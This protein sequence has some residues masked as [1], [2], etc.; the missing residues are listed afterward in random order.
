LGQALRIVSRGLELRQ[1][2][3]TAVRT[4]LVRNLFL[5]AQPQLWL[6]PKLLLAG[7][8]AIVMTMAGLIITGNQGTP[9]NDEF[10][11]A[12]AWQ[13]PT[14]AAPD[15]NTVAQPVAPRAESTAKADYQEA[16]T[17]ATEAPPFHSTIATQQQIPMAA[18][19]PIWS[20]GESSPSV[21]QA[22]VGANQ[23]L[24]A[25][26]TAPLGH[27]PT[28]RPAANRPASVER[29]PET[30]ARRPE[31]PSPYPTTSEAPPRAR[32]TGRIKV[33]PGEPTP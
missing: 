22:T 20:E 4:V 9:E 14:M 10:G 12:P 29:H 28:G 19:E 1:H 2:L 13:A 11:A 6:Q 8:G 23:R 21:P 27:G 18:Q 16:D 24:T 5:L 17:E 31:S 30:V 7:V 3:W 15:W 32:I 25:E 26:A 33:L